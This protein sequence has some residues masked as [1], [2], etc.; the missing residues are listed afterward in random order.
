MERVE[1]VP[2]GAWDDLTL[3]GITKDYRSISSARVTTSVITGIHL[4]AIHGPL[5]LPNQTRYPRV[6]ELQVPISTV[7]GR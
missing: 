6:N 1:E 3:S 4:N 5:A 7:G 2:A